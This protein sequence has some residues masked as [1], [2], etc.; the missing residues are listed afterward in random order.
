[1]GENSQ[2]LVASFEE[3]S[4]LLASMRFAINGIP[5]SDVCKAN[6]AIGVI[7]NNFIDHVAERF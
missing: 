7:L 4:I 5:K 6:E 2:V 3:K 1:M